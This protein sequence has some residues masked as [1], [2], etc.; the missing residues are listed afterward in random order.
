MKYFDCRKEALDYLRTITPQN[1]A[2]FPYLRLVTRESE[3]PAKN[4]NGGDYDRWLSCELV[5]PGLY[6]AIEDW[7]AEWDI[8]DY[9]HFDGYVVLEQGEDLSPSSA[10]SMITDYWRDIAQKNGISVNW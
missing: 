1:R 7:S 6:R 2:I 5:T 3:N 9:Y 8:M 4:I 10:V